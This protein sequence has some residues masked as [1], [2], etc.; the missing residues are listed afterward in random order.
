MSETPRALSPK[1]SQ[2]NKAQSEEADPYFSRA[3]GKALE[4]LD[5]LSGA[6]NPLTLGQL[7]TGLSLTKAS[8]F[9]LLHTLETLGYI[10]KTNN[11]QYVL[12]GPWQPQVPA[13][14][15][16]QM[17]HVGRE[18]I[19]RL[20]MQ[21][22][23]TVGL[24]ALLDNHIEVVAIMESPQLIRMGNTLGRILPPHASALGKAITAFQKPEMREKLL[25]S[26]GTPVL[27]PHTIADEIALRKEFAKI[28]QQGHAEDW[29]ESSLGGCCFAAPILRPSGI[30]A[31]AVSLSMPQ[32]RLTG[33]E[34]QKELIAGVLRTA[35][36]IETCLFKALGDST[37]L[38]PERAHK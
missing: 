29:E 33:P 31:G 21:F 30:A 7:T 13:R 20:A 4:A 22:R 27:T 35:E 38:L 19:E 16:N 11:G 24:A 36:E 18:P 23:E 17:I 25:R 37:T 32:M 3:V 28:Q 5:R 12:A 26:Y 15:V 10:S 1:R 6:G 34:H 8:T 2:L 9:R 14:L